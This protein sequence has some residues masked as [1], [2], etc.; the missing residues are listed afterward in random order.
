MFVGSYNPKLDE[1]NRLFLPAKFR[2][3]LAEG[4]VVTKGQDFCLNV[5]SIASF[6]EMAAQVQQ[7]PLTVRQAREYGRFL[8]MRAAEDKPDKQ[9]RI[10]IPAPLKE[11]AGLDRE[12]VVIGAL[13]RVEIWDPARIAAWE[14]EHS[15]TFADMSEDIFPTG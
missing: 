8:A 12:V 11:Y 13:N 7:A 15:Q 5:F 2:D 3:Q 9:G 6:T 4:L 14:T 1:K 10:T